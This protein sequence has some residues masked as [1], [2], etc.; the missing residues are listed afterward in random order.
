MGRVGHT[1]LAGALTPRL[2]V[3][4]LQDR[5]LLSEDFR[6][7]GS[8]VVRSK[9]RAAGSSVPWRTCARQGGLGGPCPLQDVG[10][11]AAGRSALFPA[12]RAPWLLSSVACVPQGPGRCLMP[13]PTPCRGVLSGCSGPAPTPWHQSTGMEGVRGQCEKPSLPRSASPAWGQQIPS[14]R[15]GLGLPAVASARWHSGI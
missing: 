4:P 2:C 7:A 8:Q 11:L 1:R 13:Q 6:T 5:C 12:P 3:Q 15:A 10:L 14:R 9:P